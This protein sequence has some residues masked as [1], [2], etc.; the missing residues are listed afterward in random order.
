MNIL[1]TLKQHP[2]LTISGYDGDPN[3]PEYEVKRNQL[4]IEMNSLEIAIDYLERCQKTKGFG[5]TYSIDSYVL[6]HHMEGSSRGYGPR[7]GYVSQGTAI[8]A[9]LLAG[10]KIKPGEPSEPNVRIA[11]KEPK[12]RVV[13]TALLWQQ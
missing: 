2:R 8:L 5:M 11:L 9:C 10:Y 3:D 7:K 12:H 13:E 1:D 4:R 6:K